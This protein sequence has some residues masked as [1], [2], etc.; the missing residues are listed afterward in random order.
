MI[1]RLLAWL[2]I[3]L[4]LTVCG[5]LLAAWIFVQG[6]G[7]LSEDGVVPLLGWLAFAAANAILLGAVIL[8]WPTITTVVPACDRRLLPMAAALAAHGL[9]L[10]LLLSCLPTALWPPLS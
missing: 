9:P 4:V 3:A 10:F 5:D 7:T 1:R 2:V 8:V 6:G